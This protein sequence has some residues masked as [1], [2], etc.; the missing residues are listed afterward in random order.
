MYIENVMLKR[1][2]APDRFCYLRGSGSSSVCLKRKIS[3]QL[4]FLTSH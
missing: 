2:I 3:L 4:I 1:I